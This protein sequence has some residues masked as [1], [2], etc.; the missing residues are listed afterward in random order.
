[1]TR[2]EEHH[3]WDMEKFLDVLG[4]KI[5]LREEYQRK[6]D[7]QERQR[8]NGTNRHNWSTMFAGRESNCVFCNCPGHRHEDCKKVTINNNKQ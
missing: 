1:M 4:G 5:D 7:R 3:E 8:K 2:G 6:P